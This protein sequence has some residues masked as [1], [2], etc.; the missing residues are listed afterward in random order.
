MASPN[1]DRDKAARILLDAIVMGDQAACDKHDISLRS[2][3][4]YRS[5]LEDDPELAKAVIE[6]KRI[7]DEKWADQIPTAIASCIDFLRRASQDCKTDDPDAV[8]AIAGAIKIMGEVSMTREV[9]DARLAE[10]NRSLSE[11][12]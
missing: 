9:I 8:H 10:Q 4:R 11:E 1:F 5:R 12:Y 6:K 2:L 3:Y 7:Q